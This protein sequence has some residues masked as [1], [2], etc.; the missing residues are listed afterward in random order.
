MDKMTIYNRLP[1]W[2]Q[3][4]ACHYEGSRIKRTR[5]G[6]DFWRF[7]AE[8]ESRAEW[9]YEQLCD[10][11]DARL[12]K[13]VHH[14]YDT[15][16]Y[17]TKLFDDG[18]INP[19]SIRTL[20]DLKVL[21]ILTK[22]IINA[23][24]DSFLSTAIPR[25]K[26]VTTHT[27]GTTGSGFVFQTTQEAISEQW[28]VWWRY[29]RALG[30]EYGTWCALLGGRSVV[31]PKWENPPFFRWNKPCRQMYFSTYHMSQSNLSAYVQAIRENNITW[32]H[33]YPS[34]INIL[35][36]FIL[37]NDLSLPLSRVSTGA[38]NLLAP[39]K[40]NIEAAF[41]IQPYQHYGL[42]ESTANFSEDIRHEMRVDE[43]F[44]AV[45]FLQNLD[46]SSYR[47]IGTCLCN[48]AMPLL[49]YATGD[50]CTVTYTAAGRVVSSLDGRKEDYVILS[51]G[52]KVGRLDHIFKDLTSI[53][54]AQFVQKRIGAVTVNIVP[55]A[56][57][58][59]EDEKKLYGEIASR[60]GDIQV[61]IRHVEKI[62]R[63]KSGKL[64]F[65]VSELDSIRR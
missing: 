6:N 11:R 7:L 33:G 23:N 47:I 49:R 20:D 8:Y 12:R 51:N 43:D 50:D 57:Y 45:E 41:G 61:E 22:D 52:A 54:E 59:A 17:Y 24:P 65:V 9:S 30:I 60:L 19:D 38:E 31:S 56:K 28:A 14:C 63:T 46:S 26:I 13:M 37:E 18:G 35:A 48:F 36:E 2:G 55:G 1:I 15:V 29:R 58:D 5:Y 16:P 53:K 34:A 3:N 10:Y 42:S 62:P 21:P 27:S 39:Q 4:L 44:A 32:L 40:K 25:K 64:R